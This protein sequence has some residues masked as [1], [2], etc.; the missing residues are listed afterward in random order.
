MLL[1][2]LH[3]MPSGNV[4]VTGSVFAGTGYS[5]RTDYLTVKYNSAGVQQ[6]KQ[7]YNGPGNSFDYPTAIAA[8]NA[9]NVII[10][11]YSTGI[12]LD[13]ATIK[14]NTNG[15]QQWI[16]RYNGPANSSDIAYALTLDNAGNV[17]V[18]GSDQKVIYN[19]DFLTVKYNSSG[20]QQWTA[21]YNGPANDN[22][23][24]YALAVDKQ[25]MYM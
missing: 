7:Q 6:W 1:L 5:G 12:D 24:S 22:D 20:V 13:F 19:S 15:V 16:A 23:E 25:E 8:D 18:T 9:G 21:R 4:Y 3:W 17:Y 2:A 14:Y 10:T 11:G